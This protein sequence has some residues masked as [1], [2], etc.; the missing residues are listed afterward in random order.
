M[1]NLFSFLFG[2]TLSAGVITLL[3]LYDDK[4]NKENSPFPSS[5]KEHTNDEDLD[6]IIKNTEKEIKEMDNLQ[7]RLDECASE[8]DSISED[9]TNAMEK[10]LS[11][12]DKQNNIFEELP[13]NS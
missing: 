4:K 2:A 10:Q 5:N 8:M 7:E 12:L 11:V 6:E 3:A 9:D 1:K 13:S